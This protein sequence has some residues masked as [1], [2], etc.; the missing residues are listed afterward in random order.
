MQFFRDLLDPTI[1]SE[2]TLISSFKFKYEIAQAEYEEMLAARKE[3]TTA[4]YYVRS[5]TYYDIKPNATAQDGN[6]SDE[7][8]PITIKRGQSFSLKDHA[9]I[10]AD[11][12]RLYQEKYQALFNLDL[13][14]VGSIALAIIAANIPFVPFVGLVSMIAWAAA[15]YF[16]SQRADLYNDYKDSLTLLMTTCNWA[17]G[18]RIH[19]D[20]PQTLAKA[21][22]IRG[23]LDSLFA[24]LTKKQ[25]KHLIDDAIEKNF[26]DAL[27]NYDSRFKFP[28]VSRMF[29]KPNRAAQVIDKELE[30]TALKQRGADV[31]RSIY[32]PNRGTTKDFALLIFPLILDI[33]R[34]GYNAGKAYFTPAEPTTPINS[35]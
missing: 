10:V 15:L 28:L 1:A 31:I 8:L 13:K 3:R 33:L 12:T 35:M 7:Q 14:I 11:H 23:M 4:F 29:S 20:D 21:P 22:E 30:N 6:R 5:A 2:K 16:I 17:L 34:A 32:G 27:E 26:V 19:A 25:A 18:T 9:V 24:V